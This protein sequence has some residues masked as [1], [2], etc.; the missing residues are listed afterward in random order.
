M[1][2]YFRE[3]KERLVLSTTRNLDFP[4]HIHEE[5]ELVYMLRGTCLAYCADKRYE[6]K[7]GD[8]FLAFPEQVHHYVESKDCKA[9]LIIVAPAHLMGHTTAFEHKAPVSSVYPCDDPDLA[10]LLTL[11]VKEHQANADRRITLP[12]LTA[13]IGKLLKHYR[14]GAELTK[15]GVIAQIVKYCSAHYKEPITVSSVSKAL[16]LSQSHI[17]HTFNEK[18]KMS[19]PDYINSLRLDDAVRLL[20]H[21]D[22]SIE[23]VAELSG[24]PTVRTFHRVFRKRFGISPSAYRKSSL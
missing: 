7:Q 22:H 12:L 4:P 2:H 21:T 15:D 9:F 5:L 13:V 23:H 20:G 17:S 3:N 8:F 18:L 1:K 19:F 10:A 24:F 6:L 16:Y 14:F 11:T